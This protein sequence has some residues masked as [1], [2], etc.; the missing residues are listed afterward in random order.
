MK[1]YR[2][3]GAFSLRR[4][5]VFSL[6][7]SVL[8]IFTWIGGYIYFLNSSTWSEGKS[9]IEAHQAMQASSQNITM[10][11]KLWGFSY[12]FS[13]D[14]ESIGVNV[15]IKKDASIGHAYHVEFER[16]GGALR[17]VRMTPD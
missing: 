8:L 5:L 15:Y 3:S 14:Y 9:L 16:S 7:I 10:T 1:H 2:K 17:L 4:G 6:A 11:P 13:G 12:R